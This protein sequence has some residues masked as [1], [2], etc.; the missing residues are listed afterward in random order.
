MTTTAA[1]I[2]I[3]DDNETDR[4]VLRRML[5]KTID[6]ANAYEVMNGAEAL[7]LL[8]KSNQVMPDLIFLDI[9]MPVMNGFEF[10]E[11]YE[12]QNNST[13]SKIILLTS[14]TNFEDKKKALSYKS[15]V[16]YFEKMPPGRHMK[17]LILDLLTRK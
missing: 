6:N 13:E 14:S 7:A 10:L 9:N 3:I 5:E 15:V 11:A 17:Q 1:D 12:Q 4:Y 16:K 2:L 8:N